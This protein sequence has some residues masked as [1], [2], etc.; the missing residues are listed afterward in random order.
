MSPELA[1]KHNKCSCIAAVF[2]EHQHICLTAEV[3]DCT[4]LIRKL[5]RLQNEKKKAKN[6]PYV[7][8]T[9]WCTQIFLSFQSFII[10]EADIYC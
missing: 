10:K 7:S 3:M 6:N 1:A 2:G 4:I 9:L 5:S 8:T